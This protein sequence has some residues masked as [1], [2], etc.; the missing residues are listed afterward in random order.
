MINTLFT[1]GYKI[2]SLSRT[3]TNKYQQTTELKLIAKILKLFEL[4]TNFATATTLYP[5]PYTFAKIGDCVAYRFKVLWSLILFIT[6]GELMQ[7]MLP[8]NMI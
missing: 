7:S 5:I 8:L 1:V 4:F 2:Q 3:E 6:L